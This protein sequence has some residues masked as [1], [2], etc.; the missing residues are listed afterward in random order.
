M[1]R[2]ACDSC[3]LHMRFYININLSRSPLRVNL[4]NRFLACMA[5]F[6]PKSLQIDG[7]GGGR[8]LRRYGRG[9]ISCGD[10]RFARLHMKSRAHTRLPPLRG[11]APATP[12]FGKLPKNMLPPEK[13]VVA[14]RTANSKQLQ[15][16]NDSVPDFCALKTK[17]SGRLDSELAESSPCDVHEMFLH[18]ARLENRFTLAKHSHNACPLLNLTYWLNRYIICVDT[19]ASY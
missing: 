9:N 4:K 18:L 5:F 16:G 8:P 13:R 11:Q 3:S 6:C 14:I 10:V 15:F 1:L 17:S 19:N 12:P 2:G 7:G